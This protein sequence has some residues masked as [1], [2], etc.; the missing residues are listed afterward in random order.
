MTTPPTPVL[1]L[2]TGITSI[3]DG[4][5]NLIPIWSNITTNLDSTIQAI[6]QLAVTT[7]ISLPDEYKGM[8]EKAAYFI[9]ACNQYFTHASITKDDMKIATTLTLFKGVTATKWAK[10]QL[11][12]IQDQQASALLVWTNFVKEFLNHFGDRSPDFTAASKIKLL[13]QG[14]DTA[15]KYNTD[16]NNLKKDMKWNEAALLDQYQTGLDADL[17]MSIF[18]SDPLLVTLKEWQDK[19]ELLDK[20]ERELKIQ[21]MQGAQ[22]KKI[23]KSVQSTPVITHTPPHII[24]CPAP[25][26]A[27]AAVPHCDPN[28][29]DVDHAPHHPPLTCFKCS[30]TSHIACNCQSNFIK[31]VNVG[32]IMDITAQLKEQGF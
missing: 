16:F 20:R 17:L 19:V 15:E 25:F 2:S 30:K 10:N 8:K 7:T 26:H 24:P 14:A 32:E 22:A 9:C 11:E 27:T 4:L 3:L 29:M 13:T 31:V 5:H 21:L 12:L 18:C 6:T 23:A 28:T 1:I